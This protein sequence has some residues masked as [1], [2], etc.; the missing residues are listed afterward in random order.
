M[1]VF[2]ESILTTLLRNVLWKKENP[3]GALVITFK[4]LMRRYSP[5]MAFDFLSTSCSV[6]AGFG[7]ED[8]VV[9]HLCFA[10]R[11]KKERG[12]QVK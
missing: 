2:S 10:V 7:K 11:N 5:M 12:T 3:L 1:A 4:S 8:E 9:K 6:K